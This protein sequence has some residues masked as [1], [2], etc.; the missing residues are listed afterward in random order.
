VSSGDPAAA[1]VAQSGAATP[2]IASIATGSAFPAAKAQARP[3]TTD[4]EIA[5]I[6][7]RI[8][9][10]ENDAAIGFIF[11]LLP[12][13]VVAARPRAHLSLPRHGLQSV[14]LHAEGATG[15]MTSCILMI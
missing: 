1:A 9:V 3:A 15:H 14:K 13:I 7:G 6:W 5:R 12:E 4:S 11:A 10:G 8:G 2:D